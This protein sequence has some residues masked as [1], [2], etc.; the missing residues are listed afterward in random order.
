MKSYN[1]KHSINRMEIKFAEIPKVRLF[2]KCLSIFL[3]IY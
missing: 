2:N 3:G 1:Y